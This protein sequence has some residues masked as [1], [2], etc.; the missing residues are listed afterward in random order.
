MKAPEDFR[1][2][3][4]RYGKARVR[5]GK[6]S[7][8]ENGVHS[9][10]EL[11][12]DVL[13][14][15]DFHECFVSGDNAHILPTD[16]IKNTVHGLAA[17]QEVGALEE[18]GEKIGRHLL[19]RSRF[20][21]TV[22]S[23]LVEVTWDRIAVDGA[24]HPHAFIQRQ[25]HRWHTEVSVSRPG[26]SR[27]VSGID[28]VCLL[29]TTA[30]AFS[31]YFVDAWTTLP[32]TRDRF[33]STLLKGRWEWR[34]VPAD[35]RGANAAALEAILRVFATEFSESVQATIF[36][37]GRAVMTAV[38]EIAR[39]TLTLPNR[40]YLHLDVARLGL[41]DRREV[42]LPT[43]EPHGQIEAVVERA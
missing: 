42:F 6:L 19:A 11:T 13:A 29:K 21:D 16:T 14:T 8:A 36:S 32:E 17:Q 5:V 24:A 3:E 40:H 23:T 33:L 27:I 7:R 37:M 30:S 31:G 18:F 25:P 35:Y 38:P 4:N 28:D 43:D 41:E 10:C 26:P 39:V 12:A 9:F 20:L 1:L 2:G 22:T 34:S 15:G